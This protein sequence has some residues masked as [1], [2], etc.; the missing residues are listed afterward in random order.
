M[1]H[2]GEPRGLFFSSRAS[3]CHERHEQLFFFSSYFRCISFKKFPFCV[4]G[5]NIWSF[6]PEP[7]TDG[8]LKLRDTA[9]CLWHCGIYRRKKIKLLRGERTWNSKH[10]VLAV[11]LFRGLSLFQTSWP[12]MFR[13]N[14]V[15]QCL[16]FLEMIVSFN[17][18]LF[19]PLTWTVCC[20]NAA[21]VSRRKK[22]HHFSPGS[23]Q[24]FVSCWL[25][26]LFFYTVV[27]RACT[28]L[29][30]RPCVCVKWR[31]QQQHWRSAR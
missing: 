30:V 16:L 29:S 24:F 8:P 13:G 19:F 14:S 22:K 1:R 28:P 21:V 6:P 17:V 5:M 23:L 20:A 27:H 26:L 10:C 11:Y 4:L 2:K 3:P 12:Q 9:L 18:F 15:V 7:V 31:Q 25:F